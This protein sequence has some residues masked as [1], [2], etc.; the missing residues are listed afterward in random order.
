MKKIR[1][2]G[3]D[4]FRIISM[5]GVVVSHTLR[6]GGAKRKYRYENLNLLEG[7]F[8]WHINGFCLIS[9]IIGYKTHK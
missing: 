6:H 2:P 9:G 1:Y 8:L 3:V 7:F 4:L 5:Y